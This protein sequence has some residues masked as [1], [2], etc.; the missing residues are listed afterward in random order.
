MMYLKISVV[1]TCILGMSG[2]ALLKGTK[3]KIL[4]IWNAV[5][6]TVMYWKF[7]KIE[8]ARDLQKLYNTRRQ[9][10]WR[11][12]RS[13]E[14]E[15]KLRS[16]KNKVNA[17]MVEPHVDDAKGVSVDELAVQLCDEN[18]DFVVAIAMRME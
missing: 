15:M 2:I 10:R 18:T 3:E 17:L 5:N 7:E 13:M 4:I 1:N 12:R 11:D 14:K 8:S 9:K 16:S 6:R